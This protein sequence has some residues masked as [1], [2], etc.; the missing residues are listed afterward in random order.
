MA[1]VTDWAFRTVCREICP[2]IVTVSEMVSSKGLVYNDVKTA[3]LLRLEQRAGRAGVQIFGSDPDCMAEAAVIASERSGADF[4]DINMGCPTPKIVKN[5]DGCAL[6]RDLPLAARIIESVVR[7]VNV[8]V[9]VKFRRGWDKGSIN[10][11]EF[12]K[13]CEA[14]GASAI[15]VHGRTKAQMYGGAAVWDEI[16]ELKAGVGIPVVVN[17]D[18]DGVDAARRALRHTRADAVMV[19]RSAFG[20]PFLLRDIYNGVS[21][22]VN[23]TERVAAARRQFELTVEDKGERSAILEARKFIGW[24]LHGLRVRRELPITAMRTREDVERVLLRAQA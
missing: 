22:N 18:I 9:T 2:E 20:N 6:M 1:G 11:V 24:Y 19:G 23:I 3:R 10:A 12:G 8:P 16:G 15:C 4:I 14:A 21:K 5:G 7:A 17:G 13:L